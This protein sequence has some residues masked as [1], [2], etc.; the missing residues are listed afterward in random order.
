MAA[1]ISQAEKEAITAIIWRVM[2]EQQPERWSPQQVG[3][4]GIRATKSG[5]SARV[6]LTKT[7]P[8]GRTAER[9]YRAQVPTKVGQPV[10]IT[11]TTSAGWQEQ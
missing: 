4:T 6:T 5:F 9:R 3:V 2:C 1:A 7:A 8:S 10:R 11:A